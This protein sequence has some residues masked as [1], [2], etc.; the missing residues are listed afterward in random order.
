MPS[1]ASSASKTVKSGIT[2]VLRPKG[3][4]ANDASSLSPAGIP[5]ISTALRPEGGPKT[6]ADEAIHFFESAAS[7]TQ[8]VRVYELALEDD[9]GPSKDRAVRRTT[10]LATNSPDLIPAPSSTYAYLLRMSP[11]CCVYRC[12][13]VCLH[14]R[15]ESSRPTFRWMEES[16]IAQRFRSACES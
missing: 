7:E 6:P 11:M 2:H 10:R 4:P 8:A 5:S 9:G 12:M 1:T 13:R 14:P 15:T 16:S 3:M